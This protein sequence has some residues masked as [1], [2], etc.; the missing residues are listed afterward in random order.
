MEHEYTPPILDFTN[1]TD[2]VEQRYYAIKSM[3]Q[4]YECTVDFT[5]VNG[6]SRSMLC[7]LR[8]DAM[9]VA[10]QIISDDVQEASS[11]VNLIT[12]WC[13]DKQAWRAMRTMNV[14]KVS[15]APKK[16][17]MTVEEDPETGDIVLPLPEDL[18]KLQGWKEG[19][20]LNW[21]DNKDGS[22]SLTKK[23]E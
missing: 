4:E 11:N 13:T 17:I 18:L 22:W 8:Q 12:V 9:P 16:W 21:E 19:D 20:T 10:T 7:T 1:S 2:T 3:L 15:L 6:E 5:K 23:A 14:T